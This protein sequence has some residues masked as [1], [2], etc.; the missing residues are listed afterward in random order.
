MG[1]DHIDE[2]KIK[3]LI[4]Q[5]SGTITRKDGDLV[6]C[7]AIKGKGD[8]WCYQI[9]NKTF[10]RLPRGIIIYV[11]D[12]G[13]EHDEQCLVYSNNG[14]MVAIDKKELIEIGFD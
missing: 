1:W 7:H 10:I 12:W 3:T 6:P 2:E 4:K 14:I 8:I 13:K 11:L 9:T 5:I